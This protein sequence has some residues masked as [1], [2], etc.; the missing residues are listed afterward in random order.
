[1]IRKEK[2]RLTT[3][4]IKKIQ[5]LYERTI[6]NGAQIGR[7]LGIPGNHVNY[8]INKIKEKKGIKVNVPTKKSAKNTPEQLSLSVKDPG[9]VAAL[10]FKEQ[11]K[12]LVIA[13]DSY[14]G[15]L[16]E[17]SRDQFNAMIKERDKI[18]EG[19]KFK[20]EVLKDMIKSDLRI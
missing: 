12:H 8:Y 9:T 2:R 19:L 17:P 7:E 13:S 11:F 16:K 10:K 6:L 15:G 20:I 1:M 14:G 3:D 18:I 5:D 4:Q